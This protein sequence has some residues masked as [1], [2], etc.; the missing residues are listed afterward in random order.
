MGDCRFCGKSAGFLRKEHKACADA[1]EQGLESIRKVCV[2]AA[3]HGVDV[4]RLA[5]R[6]RAIGTT[7]YVDTSE[8]AMAAMLGAGLVPRGECG[9]G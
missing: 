1:H 2:E 5:D 3:L 4:D 7:A 6:V 8:T 9:C